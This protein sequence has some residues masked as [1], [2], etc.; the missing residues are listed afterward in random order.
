MTGE[1]VVPNVSLR[2]TGR[3][4][5]DD[6]QMRLL[7]GMYEGTRFESEIAEA[8]ED[9]EILP[10]LV[11]PVAKTAHLIAMKLL[12][13]DDD[14]RPQDRSDLRGLIEAASDNDIADVRKAIELITLRGFH[15]DRDLAAELTRLTREG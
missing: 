8:A 9:I 2:G 4:P 3:A 7:L 11:A 10:G 13:R 1:V 5:F 15:Q 14:R 12:A 6:R